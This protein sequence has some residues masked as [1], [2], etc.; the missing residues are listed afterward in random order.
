M[1]VKTLYRIWSQKPFAGIIAS[2]RVEI[3]ASDVSDMSLI[4][5]GN[6]QENY[7]T[8]LSNR[9]EVYNLDGDWK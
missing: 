4:K 6:D 9:F 8:L 3:V 1:E 2:G 7:I 5:I